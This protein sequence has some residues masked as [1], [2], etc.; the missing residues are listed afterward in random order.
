[1]NVVHKSFKAKD[2]AIQNISQFFAEAI[3]FIHN[4]RV[5]NGNVLVHWY[6]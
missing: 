2:D 4:A 5:N 1:M 6:H 3:E